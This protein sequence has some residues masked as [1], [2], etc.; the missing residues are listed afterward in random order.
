MIERELTDRPRDLEAAVMTAWRRAATDLR[1]IRAILDA[2]AEAP[3]S[4]AMDEALTKARRKDWVLMASMAGRAS[5]GDR[6][7]ADVGRGIEQK[8]RAA[9]RPAIAGGAH[10]ADETTH[11]SLLGRIK[12]HLAV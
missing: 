7:A 11:P 12:A 4:V 6:H 9:Y 10:R 1:G 8:A 3:T 5:A 2:H